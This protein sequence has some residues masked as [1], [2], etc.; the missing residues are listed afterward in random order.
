M[1]KIGRKPVTIPSGVTVLVNGPRVHVTGPK[2]ALAWELPHGILAAV[3]ADALSLTR[4]RNDR[5]SLALHG[6]SRA[7]LAN[8]VKGVAEG[9]EKQLK[10]VGTGFRAEVSENALKLTVGFSHTVDVPIP[11]AVEVSVDKNVLITV[12][13]VDK[14]KVGQFSA[15]VRNVRPPEPYKGKG[16]MYED[17]VII[18]KAGKAAKAVGAAAGG[19]G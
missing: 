5:L 14:Q 15:N 2:G 18:R 8:M 16:I 7:I 12:R 6:T 4:K 11:Q 17:E 9:Y 19:V 1:S 10:L 3:S 13:G